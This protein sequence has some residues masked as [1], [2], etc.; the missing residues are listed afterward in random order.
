MQLVPICMPSTASCHNYL[1]LP[2]SKMVVLLCIAA[3]VRSKKKKFE[4]SER[5]R[6]SSVYP[7]VQ[8]AD[9]GEACEQ[10]S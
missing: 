6:R 3:K 2:T 9:L 7:Y 1:S 4:Y 8:R 10:S 5:F